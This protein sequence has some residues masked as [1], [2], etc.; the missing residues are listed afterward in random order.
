MYWGI[1]VGGTKLEGVVVE[2]FDPLKI[3]ARERI[4]TDQHRGYEPIIGRV[5]LLIEQLAAQVGDRGERI[6][7]AAPGAVD[8]VTGT[9]FNSNTQCM[10]GRPFKADLEGVLGVKVELENDANCFAL[11]EAS[12]GRGKNAHMVLGLILGTGV[13]AGIVID[14]KIH[15][16]KLG[17]AGEWGHQTILS[18]GDPCYCGKR[19]CVETLISGPALEKYYA[20]VA[21]QTRPLMEIAERYRAGKDTAA[22]E[23]MEWFLTYFGLALANVVN[24]LDPDVVVVGGGVSNVPQIYKG[25]VERVRRAIFHPQPTVEIVQNEL[26][27]SAGVIGAAM[28]TDGTHSY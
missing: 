7:V 4:P 2:S 28:L 21:K 27:D 25:G 1:D 11:A 6:G 16:G 19:G 10:N 26:G 3:I 22:L 8:P 17:I 13:G 9:I 23:T 20:R 14:G 15:R 5:G 12:Y 18:N 24:V